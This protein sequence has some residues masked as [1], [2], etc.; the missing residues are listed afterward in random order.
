M[1]KK[2]LI[3]RKVKGKAEKGK[4]SGK[5]RGQSSICEERKTEKSRGKESNI[6]NI[7]RSK[8]KKVKRATQNTERPTNKA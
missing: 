4:W 5:T 7:K 2:I 6:S 1:K 3:I 8:S